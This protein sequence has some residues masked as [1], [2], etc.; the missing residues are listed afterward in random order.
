MGSGG[1]KI[2]V[3]FPMN[4]LLVAGD[5]ETLQILRGITEQLAVELCDI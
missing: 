2:P 1:S 5:Q 4:R 3:G